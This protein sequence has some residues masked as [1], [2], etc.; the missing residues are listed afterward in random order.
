MLEFQ[1]LIQ[2]GKNGTAQS[3]YSEHPYL[4]GHNH[5]YPQGNLAETEEKFFSFLW[6]AKRQDEGIPLAK[7]KLLSSPKELGGVGD[8]ESL[9]FLPILGY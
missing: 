8:Q 6:S 2:R 4:F 9:S 1:I 7:W 5:L 3:C